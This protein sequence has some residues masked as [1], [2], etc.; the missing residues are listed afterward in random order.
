M[1]N[2]RHCAIDGV[3]ADNSPRPAALDKLV[4]CY[5]PAG[6]KQGDKHLHHARFDRQLQIAAVDLPGTGMD[7][8]VAQFKGGFMS[9]VDPARHR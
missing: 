3:L 8:D 5:D 6:A 2:A 9:K 4:P 1:A 7:G